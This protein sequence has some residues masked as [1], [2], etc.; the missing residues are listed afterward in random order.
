MKDCIRVPL[1]TAGK[2][3]LKDHAQSSLQLTS[4]TRAVGIPHADE[5]FFKKYIFKN[6][7]A[8]FW[9]ASWNLNQKQ[10]KMFLLE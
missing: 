3:A 9:K 7:Q 8:K 4:A 5:P 2:R 6:F 1:R 10:N